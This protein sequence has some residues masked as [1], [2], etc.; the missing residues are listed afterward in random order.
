[1][2]AAPGLLNG[3]ELT[4]AQE[5]VYELKVGQVMTPEVV[6]VSPE[7]TMGELELILRDGGFA[8]APVV[9]DGHL[10]GIVSLQ[11]LILSL[12]QG[13]VDDPVGNWMS[14]DL[15][16]VREGD[17]VIEAVKAFSQRPVG[18]IPVVDVR[19]SLVGILTGGDI[20][21]GLVRA[22]DVG[23]RQGEISQYRASHIFQDISSDDTSLTLR[24][25]I[26]AR[27]FARSGE[28]SSKLKR[29]L[30]RLGGRP[31]IVRRLAVAAYEAEMNLVIHTDD[32]GEL[33]VDMRPDRVRLVVT[34][35]GPG[36]EDVSAALE[37]GF[38]TAPDWIRDLGFGAG[39]GLQNIRRCADEFEIE[40]RPG[41][42]TRLDIVV[43]MAQEER[44][45]RPGQ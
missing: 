45:G 12:E 20:T 3:S 40:S 5:L 27:D 23:Y 44:L 9:K 26:P 14:V 6:C 36:I 39:M 33:L 4:K 19:G 7:Q 38:S 15:L 42:G 41:V 1:M 31:E 10:V 2:V 13:A 32:G 35:Q 16:T 8:G 18:R 25:R 43:R 28:A 22:L 37:P 21:R 30:Q 11:D 24:Y 29:A 17:S 34:D